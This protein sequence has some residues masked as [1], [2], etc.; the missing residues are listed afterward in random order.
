[1][2]VL[3]FGWDKKHLTPQLSKMYACGFRL[4]PCI[5][6]KLG[7]VIK[8]PGSSTASQGLISKMIKTMDY[9]IKHLLTTNEH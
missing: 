3:R 7:W 1:M 9:I 4:C 8:N 6:S 5:I 2:V